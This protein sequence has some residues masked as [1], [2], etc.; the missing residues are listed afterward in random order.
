MGVL[1]PGQLIQNS[2]CRPMLG[3]HDGHALPQLQIPPRLSAIG[4]SVTIARAGEYML[5]ELFLMMFI[6]RGRDADCGGSVSS[7]NF[8]V[9]ALV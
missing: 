5:W 2:V 4:G 9:K 6:Q 1:P 7:D 8:L 3:V